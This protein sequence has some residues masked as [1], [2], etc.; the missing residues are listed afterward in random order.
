M[1]FLTFVCRSAVSE[2]KSLE[3][4]ATSHFATDSLGFPLSASKYRDGSKAPRS[5]NMPLKEPLRFGFIK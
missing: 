5:Y 1:E 3:R 2:V 4:P